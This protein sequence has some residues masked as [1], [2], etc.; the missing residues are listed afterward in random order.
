M[1]RKE[2]SIMD[3]FREQSRSL[4]TKISKWDKEKLDEYFTSIRQIEK[5]LTKS[6][7]WAAVPKPK[8]DLQEPEKAYREQLRSK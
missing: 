6:E 4:E 8:T 5:N 7:K 3:A 2:R 1:I